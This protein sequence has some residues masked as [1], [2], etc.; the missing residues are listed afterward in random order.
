MVLPG[1]WFPVP[2][3]PGAGMPIQHI[4]DKANVG[5]NVFARPD[6]KANN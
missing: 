2:V 6:L 4:P 1:N 3:P 5:T